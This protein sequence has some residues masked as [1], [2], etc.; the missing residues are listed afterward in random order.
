MKQSALFIL[1]SLL[2]S[3]HQLSAQ[4]KA[5]AIDTL[6]NR[7]NQ[8]NLFNGAVVVGQRDSILLSKGYG[9]ANFSNATAFTPDTPADGGSIAET[10]TAASVLLLAEQQKLSLLDSVQQYLPEYPYPHTQIWNL[11]THST[12]GLPD[13][14]YYFGKLTDNRVLT[15]EEMV[16][17]LNQQKPA[18]LY[19]LYTNFSYDSPGFD[20]AAAI[21][22]RVSGD[23]YQ[24][25]LSTYF[26]EPLQMQQSYIRPPLLNEWPGERIKGYTY[27]NDVLELADI[28][29]REGFYGGSNLWFSAHDLYR[30]GRSF[31]HQP[32]LS[33]SLISIITSWVTIQGK[34]SMLRLGAWYQGRNPNAYY[35]WG[36]VAGFYSFVYWDAE[37]QFTIALVSNTNIPQWVRPQL[38]ASLIDLME[39]R[40][41]QAITEPQADK[42]DEKQL[43]AIAGKYK[44]DKAG[45]VEIYLKES[46]PY[47]K[48]QS[49]MEYRILQVDG[50]TFYVP[51]LDTWLS[52]QKRQGDAFQQILWRTSHSA[53]S[54]K[55]VE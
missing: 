29:D 41:E 17:I 35:Y 52:F 54:G 4:H 19:P 23:S 14:S 24:R 20:V 49:E 46:L 43:K 27:D 50:R 3:H 11:L 13:Y 30:W 40:K 48:L 22:A 55:R 51:G 39:G 38:T 26:F 33:E 36:S 2:C 9:Y 31:Y 28:G 37:H 42:V 8:K 34:L 32:I 15:T 18:L 16:S 25:F 7:L 12:G 5:I 6:L 10:L 1:F 45:N 21:V 47:L 53:S 44:T